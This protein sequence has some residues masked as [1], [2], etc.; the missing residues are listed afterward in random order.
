MANRLIVIALMGAALAPSA[1]LAWTLR[2]MPHLGFYHD[3]S[4][5][6]VSAR[7]LATG[8]GY[9]I[10]SLPGEP[11]Q[12]KYPPLYPALLAGIWKLNPQFPANLPLAT[13]FAWLLAPLFLAALWLLLREYGFS[14]R[15]RTVLLSIA[16]LSPVVVVFSFSLMPELLFTA[17]LLASLILAERAMRP[18][19]PRWVAV[20]AGICAALAYL[21]KSI[22]LPLLITV[23]LC[24]LLRKRFAK[25]A[26]FFAVMLPAVAGWQWW[27]A[28]HLT[29][30]WDLVTLYYTNYTGYQLYNVPPHD[31]PL[32]VWYNLDGFLQGAGKL[33][34]FDLPY[35]SKHLERVIAIAA[36][37]GCVRLA[38]RT[39]ALQYPVA[40]L[41]MTAILLVWHFPPDQRFVF[42][43]YPLLLA[44]LAT[45]ARNLCGTLR[46]AW[47]KPAF[48]DRV[49]VAGFGTL[50][51]GL[52][53]F[54][55][56]CTVFGLVHVIP[57]LFANYR[58]DFEARERAYD[59]IAHN[60]PRDASV[61]AYQDPVMFLYTGHKAC[62]LPIPPKFL[63]HSDDRGIDKLMGSMADFARGYQLDYLLLTPDDF[64]RDLNAR[65]T[66]GLT[67]AM[68]SGAFR[69]LYG[70]SRAS[71]YRLNDR[72]GAEARLGGPLKALHAG[73]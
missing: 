60:V 52:A 26:L 43:L 27:V 62:R 21:A 39:R 57:D 70:T 32:V 3:D 69:E 34:I 73:L 15:E 48:G 9:R 17:L 47:S 61:Y 28:R 56:F 53:A 2:D 16:A 40:A 31:L 58:V 37:A 7:S 44:G 66:H 29:H 72:P 54:G 5:Y 22:A 6:W 23:P 20:M 13:L 33:L 45:E 68:Q 46:T 1:Y 24:L 65:G 14:L 41:G 19:A 67:E 11:Y 49:A 35:G 30:A 8:D 64:Y 18:E 4:I 36:I 51:A 55:I 12:T 25:A 38:K 59:W 63:Y 50:L 71:V 10:Q 42:P